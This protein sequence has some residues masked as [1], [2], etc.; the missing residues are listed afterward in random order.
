MRKKLIGIGLFCICLAPVVLLTA[1]VSGDPIPPC[2]S[3]SVNGF[4][5][6]V[7]SKW[8]ASTSSATA[9]DQIKEGTKCNPALLLIR[10]EA[11]WTCAPDPAGDK[12]KTACIGAK[13]A[14]GSYKKT[15]CVTLR[16]CEWQADPGVCQEFVGQ[17]TYPSGVTLT[18]PATYDEQYMENTTNC[19]PLDPGP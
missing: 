7:P 6:N 4:C 10:A 15:L 16:R 17:V 3:L 19:T 12:S 13:N 14:D 2:G 1:R 8:P 5:Q 18:H 9:C 11:K